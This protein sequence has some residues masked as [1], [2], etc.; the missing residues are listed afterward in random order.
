MRAAERGGTEMPDRD[1]RSAGSV[2]APMIGPGATMRVQADTPSLSGLVRRGAELMILKRLY[3]AHGSDGKAYEIH[4][5]AEPVPAGTHHPTME[6]LSL[7]CTSAGEALHVVGKGR[8]Q[9]IGS[10]VM[11]HSEDPEAI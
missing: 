1:G 6:A 3:A 4:V 11:L 8:Y 5:Y 7:I 9:I 2:P 10:G